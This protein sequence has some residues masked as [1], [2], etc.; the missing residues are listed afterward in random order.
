LFQFSILSGVWGY[1]LFAKK[2]P[3]A[4]APVLGAGKGAGDVCF[5]AGRASP[6]TICSIAVYSFDTEQ[7]AQHP[8]QKS[9][10]IPD[11]DFH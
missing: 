2:Q 6:R 3:L 11:N 8:A 1:V 7:A 5:M 9:R 10:G 4:A